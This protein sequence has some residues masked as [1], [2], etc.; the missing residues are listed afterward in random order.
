MI[1]TWLWGNIN[2][3][4]TSLLNWVCTV[5]SF[6]TSG[7]KFVFA[8]WLSTFIWVVVGKI[9]IKF[10]WNKIDWNDRGGWNFISGSKKQAH[11]WNEPRL[12]LAGPGPVVT[13][14]YTCIGQEVGLSEARVLRARLK[15]ENKINR[16]S[17][18]SLSTSQKD[19]FP[20]F[21]RLNRSKKLWSKIR[22]RIPHWYLVWLKA[23]AWMRLG[24]SLGSKSG[25]TPPVGLPTAASS[26]G[27]YSF[28][29]CSNSQM[30]HTLLG[31]REN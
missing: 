24:L 4:E 23:R 31:R 10:D 9:K 22:S 29:G 16:R 11:R 26:M 21:E 19:C 18:E 15:K 27:S 28:Y 30:F 1:G 3:E 12:G 20:F 7:T 25:P 8:E 17:T 14:P 5:A 6:L 2:W 13:S